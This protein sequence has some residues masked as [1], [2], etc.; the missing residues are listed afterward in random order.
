MTV[1]IT[2]VTYGDRSAFLARGLKPQRT[3]TILPLSFT[4]P[5]CL[6]AYTAT[7]P[8]TKISHCAHV[9]HAACLL[10]WLAEEDTCPLC[11]AHLFHSTYTPKLAG[12]RV[13]VRD[14]GVSEFVNTVG[15]GEGDG[16]WGEME[17][18]ESDWRQDEEW[19]MWDLLTERYVDER[20]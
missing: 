18:R 13:P 14:F 6:D 16:G 7:N 12:R 11:R 19:G 2:T 8:A 3:C 4:C 20:D 15:A 9:F 17:E 1:T 5:I 10:T